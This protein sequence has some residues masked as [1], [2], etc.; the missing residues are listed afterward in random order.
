MLYVCM[1]AGSFM[2]SW[3]LF[4]SDSLNIDKQLE[5]YCV[6]IVTR[7]VNLTSPAIVSR[8]DLPCPAAPAPIFRYE[9][10]LY[11]SYSVCMYVYL[12]TR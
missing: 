2:S 8:G 12:F 7:T 6:E 9:S 11:L 3:S 5:R 1:Y 10:Y 4:L